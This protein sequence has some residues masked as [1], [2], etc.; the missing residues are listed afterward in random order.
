[1]GVAG[2]FEIGTGDSEEA[3][4]ARAYLEL[5]AIAHC[6]LSGRERG[7][8]FSTTALVHEAYL[9]LVD[10]SHGGWRDRAHLLAVASLAMR[11]L[12]INRARER[13][14]LK[15][16]GAREHVT[17]DEEQVGPEDQ[18][19]S[20]LQLGEALERL[21]AWAPRLASVVDCR[22]FGGLTEAET[23]DA[24]GVTVRTVR[25]DWVKARVLLR[26]ALDV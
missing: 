26:R 13:N 17:F 3:L 21:A 7:G 16:G 5:R 4:V 12:L 20:L 10:H 9:K 23:A 8:S 25:R 19:E 2:Q 22:F 14:A 1:M 18:A 6:R 24:L 11:H 15:R